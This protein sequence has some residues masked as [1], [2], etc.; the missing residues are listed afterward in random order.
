MPISIWSSATVL[1]AASTLAAAHEPARFARDIET[2][3]RTQDELIAVPLDSDVY[4]L[5]AADLGDLR[6]LDGAGQDVGFIVRTAM[7]TKSRLVERF[8]TASH[9]ALHPREQGGLEITLTLGND[10]PRPDGLRLITPLD[11]FEQH[12]EVSSSVDGVIW[13]PLADGLLFDYARYMDVRNDRLR[14]PPTDHRHFR[15]VVDQV[16]AAQ[17]SELL[18]LTRR[19]QGEQESNRTERVRIERRPFRIDR[20]ELWADNAE[21]RAAAPMTS[22][23]PL[24]GFNVEQDPEHKATH[25]L[26]E[27]RRQP[28]TEFVIQTPA[29]NFSR[30]ITV[31]VETDSGHTA[32]WRT[33][34]A[35]QLT[36]FGFR[37]LTRENL[38]I[39][40]PETRATNYRLTIE[41]RDSPP[42][43]IDGVNAS[44]PIEEVVFLAAPQGAY[45]LAYGGELKAPN[46]DTAALRA[47]LAV[48]SNPM[49]AKLSAT[50]APLA[51][52]TPTTAGQVQAWFTNPWLLT[53]VIAVL[54]AVL[55]WGLYQAARRVDQ[56]PP[57]ANSA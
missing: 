13:Q 9:P 6:V 36:R 55:A 33:I 22:A 54:V 23:Y 12:I 2:A 25:I 44:G 4:T 53:A 18:E 8:W 52:P 57:D 49:P 1:I 40:M 47:A 31:E 34:A 32:R 56:L 43:Q 51:L 7:T 39:S 5:S 11:N 15:I 19:L 27:S 30:H 28:L 26:I 3:P 21:E 14:L 50:A 16:T 45:R 10:D 29:N 37:S 35:G 17:E 20:V 41:N 42:L 46:Y 38:A 48:T 24:T